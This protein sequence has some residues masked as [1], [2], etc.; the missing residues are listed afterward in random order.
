MAI[1]A[2]GLWVVRVR[3]FFPAHSRPMSPWAT[4]LILIRIRSTLPVVHPEG[5]ARAFWAALA[6][7]AVGDRIASEA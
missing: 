5:L 1:S 3:K 7:A 4:G 2:Q 6:D